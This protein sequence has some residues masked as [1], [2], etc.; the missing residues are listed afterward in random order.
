MAQ[1]ESLKA[2]DT[3]KQT[4]MDENKL[5]TLPQLL[6]S[7][8]EGIPNKIALRFK[9][10]GI[11]KPY[12]W[13]DYYDH[14]KAFALGLVDLGFNSGDKVGI[15]GENQPPWYWGELAAQALGGVCVGIFVDA[16]P[17]EIKYILEHSDAVLVIAHDQEQ[18]DKIL[19]IRNELPLLKK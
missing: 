7:N 10:F 5:E 14:V 11:W 2:S 6:K 16:I 18:V 9:D 13:A 15:I 3:L 17:P 8:Y 19:E 12:T 4:R 1:K